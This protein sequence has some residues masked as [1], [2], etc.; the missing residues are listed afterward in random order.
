MQPGN[1]QDR[2]DQSRDTHEDQHGLHDVM[3]APVFELPSG[4]ADRA[5]ANP[6]PDTVANPEKGIR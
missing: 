6:V 4:S 5:I 2:D 1:T 3:C